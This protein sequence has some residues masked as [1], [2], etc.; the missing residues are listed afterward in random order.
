MI[1]RYMNTIGNKKLELFDMGAGASE[2]AEGNVQLASGNMFSRIVVE[3]ETNE[4]AS[5]LK[6]K[7]I[8]SLYVFLL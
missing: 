2:P 1:N 3:L 8:F 6:L 4:L 7:F 5:A